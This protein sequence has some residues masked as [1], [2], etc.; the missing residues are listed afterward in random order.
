MPV[1]L[2]SLGRKKQMKKLLAV[3]SV[4]LFAN[5]ASAD[6]YKQKPTKE[7]NL[8][9]TGY[10]GRLLLAGDFNNDGQQ[11]ML[12]LKMSDTYMRYHWGNPAKRKDVSYH[13]EGIK[14]AKED[15]D[16]WSAKFIAHKMTSSG[17]RGASWRVSFNGQDTS[18]PVGCI[19]PSQLVPAKLN[20]DSYTDF[21][22]VC[23]GYDA[24]PWPGEHSVVAVSDGPNNYN[25]TKF[26][27]G[28]GFYH[29]GDVADFNNDGNIDILIVDQ[30]KTKKAEVYLNDGIGNF[31]KSNKYF[32]NFTKYPGAYGTEIIDVNND[33]LFDVGM[34]G[35][36]N[37][38]SWKP[39]RTMIHINNGSNKFSKRN[40]L[41]VPAVKDWGTVLDMFVEGDNLF[42]LRSSSKPRY[43]GNMV[44]HVDIRTMK[45]VSTIKNSDMDWYS[46]I[47]RKSDGKYGSL[48][49]T[50]NS[51]DFRLVD[52]KI[53]MVN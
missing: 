21:V 6:D 47:F 33:G 32:S 16:Q 11:E 31:S 3:L 53:T 42:V 27:R 22:I 30:G 46:R 14:K 13:K 26:T 37:K 20:N 41:I 39:H 34:F 19:Q 5:Q 18:A 36:E 52:G 28:V 7:I 45:T 15:P 40:S 23:H 51:L 25:V 4:V 43:R 1:K 49:N 8:T 2:C 9:G 29:D 50:T 12:Y 10:Y 24:D 17:K 35:H 44:Q 48:T 38:E